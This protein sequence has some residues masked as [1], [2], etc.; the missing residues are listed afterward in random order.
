M[1]LSS[2]DFHTHTF[3]FIKTAV[4][5]ALDQGLDISTMPPHLSVIL[6]HTSFCDDGYEAQM[7]SC[8]LPEILQDVDPSSWS[9]LARNKMSENM[10]SLGFMFWCL[11]E[12]NDT[13]EETIFGL[14]YHKEEDSFESFTC[15]KDFSNKVNVSL[16]DVVPYL[17]DNY[18]QDLVVH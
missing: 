5:G 6:S 16:F 18:K 8:T 17:Y 13:G 9:W 4:D 10:G 11:V 2:H 12:S 7:L 1:H 15:S 14:S 3:D